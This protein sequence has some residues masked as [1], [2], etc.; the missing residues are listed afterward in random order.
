[1]WL[2][3]SNERCMLCPR[4]CG[5]DRKN[6]KTGFCLM[7]E[8]IKVARAALHMWEEPCISG[9]GKDAPGSGTVFF[10]GCTLR[11]VYCQNY[12]IAAG[13]YGKEITVERLGNIFLELQ[14]KGAANINLVTPTHYTP[15]IIRALDLVKHR[16]NIP[17]LS[18]TSGYECVE[19]LKM[20]EGYVDIYLTD[21]KYMDSVLAERYSRAADYPDVTKAALSEMVRQTGLPEF[22]DHGMMKKGVIVRHLMLPGQLLD[23]KRIVRYIY[24]T[25]G[26]LVYLSLMNQYT[27]LEHVKNIPELNCRV[28]KKSYNKLVDFAIGLGVSNAFIQGGEAAQES[29]IPAFECEGV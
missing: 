19:T 16:M 23:S 2:D 10:S 14:E 17:V 3:E 27:P 9:T 7:P 13:T 18:N 12:D 6:N 26:D 1:M 11:C 25:Y 8:T 22:D 20:F 15:Q 29:F 21:F 4:K 5:A 24:E 28:K